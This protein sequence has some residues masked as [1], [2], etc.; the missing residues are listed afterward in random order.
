MTITRSS[1]RHRKPTR[2]VKDV[3]TARQLRISP[4]I[5]WY[6]ESRGI[7][8]PDCPPTTK[9]PEPRTAP[10]AV[11]DPE[12]VDRVLKVFQSLRHVSGKWAG[13]P[14]RPDPWQIAYILAPVFGWVRWDKEAGCYV[15]IIRDLYVDVPRKNGK[16]TLAAGIAIYMACA[17]FEQGAQVVTAA[18]SEKQAGFVFQPIKTLAEKAPALKGQVQ[19]LTKKVIHKASGSYIEVISAVADAQHGANIH[20][21]I[22]D[23]L[24]VH[25]TAALLD[26]LE[27]G[28][29]SRTQPLSVIITTAD[30]GKP[31]TPYAARRS[32]IDR[33]A[34]RI[35]KD[36][37]T[38]GVIWGADRDDDPFSEIVWQRVNPGL[39]VSPSWAYL[40]AEAR[41]AKNS[42]AQLA[43]FKRLHLGIR[44]KQETKFIDLDDWDVNGGLVNEQD[45]KGRTCYAGLDL[46]SVSDLTSICYLFPE[47]PGRWKV[48]WRF[49]M[50]ESQLASLNERTSNAA[51]LWVKDGWLHVTPGNVT[52]YN[53]VKA[54]MAADKNKFKV[55]SVAFDRWNASQLVIDLQDEGFEM[56]RLG[57]GFA[58]LSAPM[59]EVQ[60]LVLQGVGEQSPVLNHGGNPV[61][62]WMTDNLAVAMDTAGN[63]K[64][65]KAVAG[66]KIDGWSA[67]ANAMSEALKADPAPVSAYEKNDVRAV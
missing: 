26:T 50:P 47:G 63:V 13:K 61:M 5:E 2:S 27:T 24:H 23:E 9:T 10:G 18:T 31:N 58:S 45:L 52:D 67:L 21:S 49:W 65:D 16:S 37:A 1:G 22:V 53:Y 25:K 15:R 48:I 8:L 39:G 40:R 32:T 64:P 11:F 17:D 57:Q 56:V 35:I 55:E 20:C 66:D 4:E 54:A 12:R 44:T 59:K 60:R 42:P 43:I 14:L 3:L 41:K 7:P 29:G 51:D 33:L 28:R 36:E 6:F 46:G 34:K 62:R 38:Y 30:S 19:A